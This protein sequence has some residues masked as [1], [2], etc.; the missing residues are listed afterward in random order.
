M[1]TRIREA[2]AQRTEALDR[3][4]NLKEENSELVTLFLLNRKMNQIQSLETQLA[5][6]RKEKAKLLQDINVIDLNF[7]FLD[8]KNE[9]YGLR[10][11]N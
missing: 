1:N 7:D 5:A 4:R 9:T 6:H 11:R 2:E 10:R 8:R 3:E